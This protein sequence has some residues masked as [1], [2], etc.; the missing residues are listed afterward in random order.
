METNLTFSGAGFLGIYHVGVISCLK[1][2]GTKLLQNIDKI[3]GSSAGALSA[4]MLLCNADLEESVQFVMH[5][6]SK[7]HNKFL[8]PINPAFDPSRTIRRTFLK[9]LPA[10]GYKMASGKL[11]ISLTR[12]SDWK[13]VIVSEF[14]SNKDLVDALVCT[15]FIP[16]FSGVVPPKF[17]GE[18]YVDG[19]F[20]DNLP[21]EFDGVTITVSPFSGESDICPDDG[22]KTNES[23]DFKNTNVQATAHNAYRMVRALFP[24]DA[25]VLCQM[26]KQGFKDTLK[27]LHVHYPEM[28]NIDAHIVSIPQC[29]ESPSCM[30]PSFT[31][32]SSSDDERGSTCSCREPS[33]STYF[34][35]MENSLAK[36]KA[37]NSLIFPD[38]LNITLQAAKA[39]FNES[40]MFWYVTT[41]IIRIGRWL[42]SP[43][44]YMSQQM[45]QFIDGIFNWLLPKL[46]EMSSCNYYT[47]KALDIALEVYHAYHGTAS[48][49]WHPNIEKAR[50]EEIVKSRKRILTAQKSLVVLPRTSESSDIFKQQSVSDTLYAPPP[51]R[52]NSS[53]YLPNN[54]FQIALDEVFHEYEES[55]SF[56]SDEHSPSLLTKHT[57]VHL[58]HCVKNDLVDDGGLFFKL[59]DSLVS[60]E[61]NV[62]SLSKALEQSWE[63]IVLT[64]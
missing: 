24:P 32:D 14:K 4:C 56:F 63:N 42:V 33:N 39:L 16:M 55:D 37:I 36:S 45:F 30:S 62:E 50:H 51:S 17:M 22:L 7:V 58:P 20:T 41:A 19:G 3:G 12:V 44:Y 60:N 31:E 57:G 59:D 1:L 52:V 21:Q 27:Y 2:Y 38:Q 13:N 23:F 53:N 48:F 40:D 54:E 25:D 9:N 18:M 26:C 49:E 46:K 43:Y 61:L 34:S 6:A 29:C 64:R 10:N 8:G 28:L 11:Y 35:D 5:L 15:C 47:A